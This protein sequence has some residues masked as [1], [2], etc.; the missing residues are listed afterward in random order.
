MN[1][2]IKS[3]R[4]LASVISLLFFHCLEIKHSKVNFRI[5]SLPYSIESKIPFYSKNNTAAYNLHYKIKDPWSPCFNIISMNGSTTTH[6][7]QNISNTF[8]QEQLLI[9]KYPL[10][11]P[12]SFQKNTNRLS[13][14]LPQDRITSGPAPPPTACSLPPAASHRW[15]LPTVV[16]RPI[17]AM[18]CRHLLP[19]PFLFPTS[20][21]PPSSRFKSVAQLSHHSPPTAFYYTSAAPDLLPASTAG[22]SHR[23][24]LLRVAL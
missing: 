12:T 18:V 7:L 9:I 4:G 6:Y 5:Y 8:Q 24:P 15:L 16:G 21:S 2:P 20:N 13:P 19:S 23:R 22:L 11:S 3:P 14:S 17:A 10:H 1:K